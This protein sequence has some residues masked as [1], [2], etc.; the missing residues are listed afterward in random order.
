MYQEGGFSVV[1]S[2]P[3]GVDRDPT[4][5]STSLRPRTGAQ[6]HQTMPPAGSS[7]WT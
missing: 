6:G 2:A 5:Y 7:A 4:D 3:F 1:K